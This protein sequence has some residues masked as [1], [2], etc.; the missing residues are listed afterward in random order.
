[1]LHRAEEKARNLYSDEA[2]RREDWNEWK[3]QW[4]ARHADNL[5]VCSCHMC[6]NPRKHYD[7][8][9]MQEKK[10]SWYEKFSENVD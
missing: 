2:T 4:A 10:F 7:E 6:G 1:M 5:T 8:I 9:T 3:K